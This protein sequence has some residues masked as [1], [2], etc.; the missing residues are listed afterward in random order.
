MKVCVFGAG[1]IGAYLGSALHRG[2]CDVSLV[3]QGEHLRAIQDSGLQFLHGGDREVLRL[4]ACA[5][6]E[7][8]GAFDY[9]VIAVK[10][11]SMPA[12]LDAIAGLLHDQ[13]TVVSAHNGIPWWYF[14]PEA[15]CSGARHLDSV[16]PGGAQWRALDAARALGCVIYPA[17]E[18]DGPG[19]V[20][21]ISGNRVA[22]GEPD[23]TKSAR[24]QAL[25][26]ALRAGG[27]KAPVKTDI[28]NDLWLKL[29]GNLAFN[30]LSVLSGAT[31]AQ[32]CADAHTRTL[33]RDM[34]REGQAV[35]TALGAR[36]A[37]DIEQRI[38][39]AAAVGAHKTS[40][41]QD[42]EAGLP[43][44]LDPVIGAVRELGRLCAVAT[45]A[46]DRVHA[47]V[48][49]SLRRRDLAAAEAIG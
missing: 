19:V 7:V 13:C 28:R 29:V 48:L 23:G 40:M 34:M 33:A 27:V 38:D 31:L 3:D 45:P 30:P 21:H 39:G 49:D 35:A 4:P 14:H 32:L 37:I 11:W 36:L 10:T 47:E 2:G 8:T 46:I 42:F 12:A 20:R 22:L 15:H 6:G 1:G 24:A 16:D 17:C 9:V 18:I 44:E 41:L 25:S 26:R 5:P 43:L